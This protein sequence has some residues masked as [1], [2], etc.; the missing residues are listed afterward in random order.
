MGQNEPATQWLKSDQQQQNQA[1]PSETKRTK[2]CE[3]KIDLAL[4][5]E[6]GPSTA[7]CW[8]KDGRNYLL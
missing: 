4:P 8:F 2:N 5:S 3:V 7:K 1:L 6:K